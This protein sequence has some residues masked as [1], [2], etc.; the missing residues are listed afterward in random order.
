MVIL[1]RSSKNGQWQKR[2][3]V[4]EEKEVK[5]ASDDLISKIDEIDKIDEIK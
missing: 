4:V 1:N 3:P 2:P 5:D